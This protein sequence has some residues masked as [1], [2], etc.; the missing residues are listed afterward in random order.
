LASGARS[1]RDFAVGV[2]AAVGTAVA[3]AGPVAAAGAAVEVAWGFGVPGAEEP[4]AT[5][6]ANSI[7]GRTVRIALALGQPSLI[8]AMPPI[9]SK[10]NANH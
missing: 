5:A 9:V 3:T 6:M 7:A 8:I 2:G 10:I 4:Q 1:V